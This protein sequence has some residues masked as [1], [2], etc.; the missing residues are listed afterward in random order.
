MIIYISSCQDVARDVLQSVRTYVVDM[1]KAVQ[2]LCTSRDSDIEVIEVL[3]F[4]FMI[5]I[6]DKL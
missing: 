3:I 1:I 5:V 2:E 6:L 4:S